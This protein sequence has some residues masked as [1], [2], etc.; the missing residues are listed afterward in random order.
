MFNEG[1]PHDTDANL[2]LVSGKPN[3]RFGTRHVTMELESHTAAQ[4]D[5][6]RH[7]TTIG[8]RSRWVT[9]T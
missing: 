3:A 7:L 5:R 2:Q 6:M 4:R 1:T 9:A 8:L